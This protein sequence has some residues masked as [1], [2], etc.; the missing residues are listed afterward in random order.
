MSCAV[1]CAA[2]AFTT[3]TIGYLFFRRL[4]PVYQYSKFNFDTT[5]SN[6]H[7]YILLLMNTRASSARASGKSHGASKAQRPD[8]NFD[9][10]LDYDTRYMVYEYLD[11][12]RLSQTNVGFA[13]SCS[14][15]LEEI[16]AASIKQHGSYL[17][18]IEDEFFEKTSHKATIPRPLPPST[19]K[20]LKTV[21][22]HVSSSLAQMMCS[23][24]VLI[25]A[26]SSIFLMFHPIFVQPF[27]IVS[28]VITDGPDTY[29]IR[30]NLNLHRNG[31][32][33]LQQP[34][35]W[36]S[37]TIKDA[38]YHDR[39]DLEICRRDCYSVEPSPNGLLSELV[40]QRHLSNS[41]P[42][43]RTQLLK[44]KR[45]TIAWDCRRSTHATGIPLY[46]HRYDTGHSYL[47]NSFGVPNMLTSYSGF[48][49]LV[50]ENKLVGE[51][52]IFSENG[53]RLA[54]PSELE[55]LARSPRLLGPRPNCWAGGIGRD[56]KS[57]P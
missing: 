5:P 24:M 47:G 28:I 57:V 12:P 44:T 18:A 45:I 21:L 56:L 11:M 36:L 42:N 6:H 8:S 50:S 9:A 29:S 26:T 48:Y 1:H 10:F 43:T 46:G 49:H 16:R 55:A 32:F 30:H 15:A 4:L 23:E 38:A 41:P 20:Q 40:T 39:R 14:S 37:A 34:L 31:H 52:G 54:E 25:K 2:E 22:I 13:M 51:T 3:A 53:W 33:H 7:T 27:D 35:D 17:R 19:F